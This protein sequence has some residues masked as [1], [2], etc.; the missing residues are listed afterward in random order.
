MGDLRRRDLIKGGVAGGIGVAL[1]G[2]VDAGTATARARTETRLRARVY[3]VAVVGAGLAGLTAARR[4]RAAGRSAIVLE[5]R[6]RVGGRNFDHQLGG[7]KVAEL[8]GQWA[9]PG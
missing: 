9:G 7:G 4:V 6:H 1:G 3:D 8:G 2:A 5:A